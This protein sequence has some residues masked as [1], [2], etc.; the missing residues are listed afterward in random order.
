M[1][2]ISIIGS[3]SFG[4]ALSVVLTDNGHK[5]RLWSRSE[6]DCEELKTYHASSRLPG[7]RLSLDIIH[8]T[9]IK[10]A[11]READLV[12]IAVASPAIRSVAKMVGPYIPD[13]LGVIT[14]SKGIEEISLLTMAEVISQEIP[15][16]KVGVLS[17]PS[18]A[19][20]VINR[21]PTVVVSGSKHKDLALYVQKIFINSLFRVYTSPDVVGIEIGA[22]LKNVIALAAGIAVGLGFGD[23]IIA[24][25]ITRGSKE[26]ST[27]A[28]A[29]GGHPDTLSGLCGM[30]DLIVTC[31]STHSRNRKAGYLI[32][33]GYSVENALK[34][35]GSVVEGINSARSALLLGQ[36]YNVSL[37]IV[38][39]INKVLFEGRD[40]GAGF[41]SLME[42][43]PVCEVKD[44]EW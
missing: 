19:E 14:A 25:L 35:V 24:A 27:L 40:A 12:V 13:G 6:L 22:A 7:A 2:N 3:G 29:M 28:V 20:E 15:H 44:L 31:Q 8:T 34:E 32:G 36:K 23:N 43:D 10:E 17:G 9:D 39:E 38:E 30:G 21:L 33:K 1:A 26:I 18:H 4:C 42:R 11:L 16:A 41:A 37:P 5:V